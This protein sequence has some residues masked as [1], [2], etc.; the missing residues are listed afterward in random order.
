MEITINIPKNTY[1]VPTEVRKDVVEI[2]CNAFINGGC[3]KVF[4]PCSDGC[5]RPAT[6]CAYR[7]PKAVN[8]YGKAVEERGWFYGFESKGRCA[9][10]TL[11]EFYEVRGCE[12]NVAFSALREAGWH[13]F[14][15]YEFGT[16]RGYQVSS[17]PY[18]EGGSEVYGFTDFID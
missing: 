6:L 13:I 18:L 5:C 14:R 2:I 8:Q 4:H 11:C 3:D 12:M 10:Y 9:D 7:K 1:S 17:K 16:W 15:V